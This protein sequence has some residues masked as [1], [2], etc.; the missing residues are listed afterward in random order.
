[1]KLWLWQDGNFMVRESLTKALQI[2][3]KDKRIALVGAGG[4]T[5]LLFSLAEEAREQG[6]KVIVT[7]TT[8]IRRPDGFFITDDDLIGL[9]A[10]LVR[11][12]IAIVGS[13]SVE[14]KLGAA[15]VK[16]LAQAAGL[17]DV[18]LIEA[19]G[20]HMLP[21]KAP[22]EYEPVLRGD[23]QLVIAVAG[24]SAIG[25]PIAD[26]CHRPKQVMAILGKTSSEPLVSE[27]IAVLLSDVRGGRKDVPARF[28]VVLNQVN[29]PEQLQQAVLCAAVL[30]QRLPEKCSILAMGRDLV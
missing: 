13:G 2:S 10:A 11:Q 24:M 25:K 7:T 27:D 15:P 6:R 18:V 4:K 28:A 19:D 21:V 5:T 16:F 12:G 20:S 29:T 3:D 26:V 14:E 1:M 22:A 23:E 8:H 17:A 9:K 30:Q